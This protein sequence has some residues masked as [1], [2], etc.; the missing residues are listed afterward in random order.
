M[1]GSSWAMQCCITF[2]VVISHHRQSTFHPGSN[3]TNLTPLSAI[4]SLKCD[5]LSSMLFPI[6][7]D[8]FRELIHTWHK[9]ID[10]SLELMHPSL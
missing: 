4:T 8:R 7:L 1:L 3:P 9:K 2:H 5:S 6:R 10:A